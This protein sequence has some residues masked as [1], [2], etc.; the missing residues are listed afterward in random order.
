MI[1][2]EDKGIII[3]FTLPVTD[4]GHRRRFCCFANIYVEEQRALLSVSVGVTSG[5][6]RR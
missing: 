1:N 2:Y 3:D 6:A 4:H 5:S